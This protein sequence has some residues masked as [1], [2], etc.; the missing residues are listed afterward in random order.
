MAAITQTLLAFAILLA[1]VSIIYLVTIARAYYKETFEEKPDAKVRAY[2]INLAKNKDRMDHFRK[3]YAET[4][5]S[6]KFPYQRFEAINGREIDVSKYVT[7]DAMQG[8]QYI[9]NTGRR[10]SMNQL[11]KG[12]VGCYLSHLAVYR[13][14]LDNGADYALVFED[15]ALIAPDV[16]DAAISK[17]IGAAKDPLVPKTWDIMLLG[18]ICLDCHEINAAYNA[19]TDFYGLHGYLI[20]RS[21]ME[22]LKGL[23]P[24]NNQIDLE[25]SRLSQARKLNVYSLTTPKVTTGPFGTDL[26]ML[27]S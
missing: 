26:Q 25:M 4:D 1:F 2:V 10:T 7:P 23:L 14:A 3:N 5:L 9:E 18:Y 22:K 8:I 21:G 27:L 16:Y 15:D 6:D 12:M 20:S 24:I 19:V 11:T 13:D 17:L